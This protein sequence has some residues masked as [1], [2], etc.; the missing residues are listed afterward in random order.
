MTFILKKDTPKEE[1]DKFLALTAAP[2][3]KH[4]FEKYVGKI[5]FAEDPLVIQ[6]KI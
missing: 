4:R 2:V 1:F 5:K 6:Q 3:N